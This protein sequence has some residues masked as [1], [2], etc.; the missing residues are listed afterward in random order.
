MPTETPIPLHDWLAIPPAVR[1]DWLEVFRLAVHHGKG[2]VVLGAGACE[3]VRWRPW[4]LTRARIDALIC[5]G[6]AKRIGAA[7]ED[8]LVSFFDVHFEDAWRKSV[9]HAAE[10]PQNRGKEPRTPSRGAS[11]P[12][13]QILDLRSEDRRSHRL[14]DQRATPEDVEALGQ[15][16]L[17]GEATP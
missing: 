11:R 13:G 17:D 5:Y 9:E 15:A 6:L 14:G 8:I 4:G 7:S 10:G 16:L 3:T 2:G 1:G 12:P